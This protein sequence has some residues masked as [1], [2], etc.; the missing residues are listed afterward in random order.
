[1]DKEVKNKVVYL[2]RKK[3]EGTIF[4]VGMGDQNRAYNTHSRNRW[5]TN[6]YKKHDRVVDIVAKNLSIDDAYE[7]EVFLISEI[8]RKD[9][10]LG[11]LVNLDDGGK[12]A[13]GHIPTQN[14]RNKLSK[15]TSKKVINTETLEVLKSGTELTKKYGIFR[16]VL[17]K[18]HPNSDWMQLESYKNGKHLTEKWINRYKIKNSYV[19]IINTNTLDIFYSIEE[20]TKSIG[21]GSY[22]NNQSQYNR[23]SQKLKGSIKNNSNFMYYDDYEKGLHLT[24]EWIRRKERKISKREIPLKEIEIYDFKKQV[25]FKTTRSDFYD[26]YSIK[27]STYTALLHG[28]FCRKEYNKFNKTN[29]QWKNILNIETNKVERFNQWYLSEKLG[30]TSNTVSNLFLGRTEI[31]YKKYKIIN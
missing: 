22:K 3:S 21:K 6:V 26:K 10:G 31:L 7:L 9:L 1:M 30:V 23:L 20:A 27:P 12:G 25:W 2:H 29:N 15:R 8:G 24:K 28:R 4:Y 18:D 17:Q 14:A 5:W 13:T 11:N 16:G 19:K